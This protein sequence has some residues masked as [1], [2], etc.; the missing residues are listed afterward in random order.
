MDAVESVG[1]GAL[2]NEE[3]ISKNAANKVFVFVINDLTVIEREAKVMPVAKSLQAQAGKKA[4][5]DQS[6]AQR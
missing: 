5:P 1:G 6:L 2:I 3:M 4:E